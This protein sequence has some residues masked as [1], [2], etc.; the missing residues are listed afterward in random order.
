MSV[1]L[2]VSSV[3]TVTLTQPAAA[4]TGQLAAVVTA[5][6]VP[7]PRVSLPPLPPSM[8]QDLAPVPGDSRLTLPEPATVPPLPAATAGTK[9]QEPGSAFNPATS[10]VI[11]RKEFSRTWSNRDGTRT[12]ELSDQPI[13]VQ[14]GTGAWVAAD[15]AVSAGA[16]GAVVAPLHPLNPTF[17]PTAN[18]KK[19][20]TVRSGGEWVTFGL[21]G[22]AASPAQRG[23]EAVS[24]AGVLPGADLR[25][26]TT[27]ATVKE[28][29]VLRSAPGA[30]SSSWK[31][32]VTTSG[33]QPRAGR[34]GGIDFVDAAGTVVIAIPRA[35]MWDSSGVAGVSEPA[36]AD[37]ALSVTPSAGGWVLT[38]TAD[39]AWLAD[40]ARVYPVYVD[41]TA[42]PG[43]G[44][45]HIV[46]Y[47]SD[48]FACENCG[49]RIGNSRTNNTD[50][51]YRALVKYNYE[52]F[53]G[54]QILDAQLH[55]VV[56][57]GTANVAG[58]LLHH[59]TAFSY[60]GVGTML[61]PFSVGTEAWIDGPGLAGQLESWNRAGVSGAYLMLRAG[62]DAG[63][64]TYKNG[65][66]SLYVTWNQFPDPGYPSNGAPAD[67]GLQASVV[68][69]LSTNASDPDGDPL[70]FYYRVGTSPDVNASVVWQSGWTDS[71][72]VKI[73]DT[74]PLNAA[75][76]YYWRAFVRDP[77]LGA[78]G[79]GTDRWRDFS[80]T[81]HTPAPSPPQASAQPADR[82]VTTSTA[83]TFTTAAV[84]DPDG[85]PV[86]YR[87]TVAT[88][89]DGT[90][91][92]VLTSEWL[93]APSWTPPAGVLRDGGTYTWSVTVKD[94]VDSL[95]P[96]WRNRLTVNQRVGESGPAP[97]DSAGPV[98][99]NLANGNV[100]L[101][102]SSP[103][104]NTVGGPMGL[105]F[106][107][108]SLRPVARGLTGEY[109]DATTAVTGQTW[110]SFTGRSPVLTRTDPAIAY[111]WAL[112]SPGPAVPA[113]RFLIRWKGFVTPP[114]GTYTFGAGLDDGV[115]IR[116][117]GVLVFDNWIDKSIGGPY[118][119]SPVAFSGGPKSIQ[120]EYA[121]ISGGA[122]VGLMVRS[123]GQPDQV[124][125]PSWLSA[126]VPTLPAGWSAS[127]ALSGDGGEYSHAQVTESS[128]IITDTT[129]TAH[130]Y[131][132]TVPSASATGSPASGY[133]APEGEY[134]V[135]ALDSAGQVTLTEE[136]GAVHVFGANGRIASTTSPADALKP[137]APTTSYRPGTGQLNAITDPLSERKVR[138]AYSGDTM[139][140]IGL[141]GTGPA[142]AASGT[143][144][145]PPGGM[146]CRIFYPDHDPARA[147]DDTT[148]LEYDAYGRLVRIIDPGTEITSFGYDPNDRLFS[149]QDSVAN[150]W[151]TA[152]ATR[153]F[154]SPVATTIDYDSAGRAT[155]VT[156]P[157]ADGAKSSPRPGRIYTYA[158]ASVPGDPASTG[159][160]YVDVVGLSVPATAP[161]NG[162]ARTV[163]FDNAWRQLTDTSALGL[164]SRQ[165][166]N[167]RDMVLSATDPQG[168]MSTTVYDGLDRATDS[169][170]P[171]PAACFDANRLP[172]G[173]CPVT[174][175]HTRTG[176][177]EGLSGLSATYYAN[178]DLQGQPVTFGLGATG[179]TDGALAATWTTTPPGV[180]S[181]PFSARFTGRLTFPA[182][183]T[184]RLVTFG[185]DVVRLWVDDILRLD[186]SGNGT[187]TRSID[188][189]VQATAGQQSRIRVEYYGAD[190][191]GNLDL[192]WF[193]AAGVPGRVPGTQLTPD[194]GLVTSTTTDDSAPATAVGG[195]TAASARVPSETSRT[196]YDNP[197]LG[198]ATASVVDPTGLNLR[199]VTAYEAIGAGYLRRTEKRLPAAVSSGATAATAGITST[200]YG[201][202]ET[203]ATAYPSGVPC[204][205]PGTTVQAGMQR[206]ALSAVPSAGTRQV[207]EYVYD[208][209]GRA[210]GSRRVADAADP[211][212][213]WTCSTFDA[214][215]RTLTVTHPAYAGI[216]AR[217]VTSRYTANGLTP[218]T[219]AG[220]PLTSSVQDGN[221]PGSPNSGTIT[222]VSDLLGRTV[223][224]TD[225]WGT[226]SKVTYDLV[227]RATT[228]TTTPLGGVASVMTSTYDA[229][230]KPLTQSKDGAV[231]AT[232]TYGTG[233]TAGEL[234]GATYP[235]GTGSTGNG[236]SLAIGKNPAGAL[237]SLGWTFPA[238]Q[239]TG[240]STSVTDRVVRSQSGR[241]VDATTTDGTGTGAITRT[242]SYTYDRAGR[243]TG[244]ALPG[245]QLGYDYTSPADCTGV[246]GAVTNAGRN[247]NRMKTT[248]TIPAGATSATGQAMTA[249]TT[250]TGY[251]Y[252]AADRLLSTTTTAPPGGANP[253][254]AGNL[255]TAGGAAATLAYDTH[256]N[257]TRLADQT[258]VYD[259]ADRH[260]TTTTT[261]TTG[262]TP[263]RVTYVRDAADRIVARTETTNPGATGETSTT[264][265]YSYSAAGDTADLTLDATSQLVERI[266]SLPGGVTVTDRP[267][268]GAADVWA[269]PNIHG[270]V[271][272]TT[273]GAGIRTGRL[274][275]YDPFG[276][277][278]DPVSGLIGTRTADDAG[279]NTLTGNLDNGWL[280][281]HDR[282]Y[283]H[284]GSI[285]TTE[286]GAR[287]YVPA[288]G[289]FLEIDP[290]EGGVDNDYGYVTDP[291]NELDLDGQISWR[292]LAKG[293]IIVGAVAGAIACGLSVV[294]GLA[295][296]AAAGA[297]MYAAAHAGT[298]RFRWGG[299]AKGAAI[300]G[301]LGGV[302]RAR[303]AGEALR[304]LPAVGQSS[305]LFGN[306]S[307]GA[308]S[309]R[310][311]PP[312]RSGPRLGWSVRNVNGT[313]H[314]S[315]RAKV[316]GKYVDLLNGGRMRPR[317]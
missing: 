233:T 85:T 69:T 213:G 153:P 179:Q 76:R 307:M 187:N 253:V 47:K 48:G 98:S 169:Y 131:T 191:T 239:P 297:G 160:S 32:D 140:S 10:V 184:Y 102:F 28:M 123:T 21:Q 103:T 15:G 180:P 275:A 294:C 254:A 97:I 288:L 201:P 94:A 283:E 50:T 16:G 198:M 144:Q 261:A 71:R 219:P 105:T 2:V 66:T 59:A 23:V 37:V 271:L 296:G 203:L 147:V 295:V 11:E 190:S 183:G 200:Y 168:R 317:G 70:Q 35:G 96:A 143:G 56:Q 252:D 154:D 274:T 101:G 265:R 303:W 290:I 9:G 228:I 316:R 112:G 156:L 84:S 258:L 218:G 116:V 137:A 42:A 199:T 208:G 129:G 57:T 72:T 273:T 40:P 231:I 279:P 310:F 87:F 1:S 188:A 44:P 204:G 36:E 150:D 81:T 305:R 107:Y 74:A 65:N 264:Q 33:L 251:C 235:T 286:M 111:D 189:P 39:P 232:L 29:L 214:R 165:A 135:L 194:F 55:Y 292:T 89:Q 12:T 315:F 308:R 243:L 61:T 262:S 5:P 155:A 195:A 205:L 142:C 260:V 79:G 197:W 122:S 38:Q 170:G 114:A 181:G 299:L 226:V 266:H 300:G 284:A 132:K 222:T 285:A 120:V 178:R 51:Y 67:A 139:A 151:L 152:D 259:A 82:T 215:G 113:D 221:V 136:D 68:P 110:D 60:N 62:E 99:V 49:T 267:A 115:R 20:L 311:N 268:A 75:T 287:A 276:Q 6:V 246:T 301:A 185:D 217:T 250:A 104:V 247:G 133:S 280:G 210:V 293:A 209:L 241:V 161:S 172:L 95:R 17:A 130:T 124:L 64:Y 27:G 272:I 207:L 304:R 138:F 291:V 63:V 73:P 58:G 182:A 45:N 100:G 148:R 93:A 34:F 193:D 53:D 237:T 171:A 19:L 216:A 14:S 108:N 167:G 312:G 212:G 25:F 18:S 255:T 128:V 30:G 313:A 149:V 4:D 240:V 145:T 202:T 46:S 31:W 242:A 80:F 257:T 224:T 192:H 164:S 174:P 43:V 236:T 83:P 230:G 54:K 314:S 3:L 177:D 277:T 22:A 134:G 77:Y 119:G 256:G 118:Y 141:T 166:W 24:Y 278:V 158:T 281:Q 125:P 52:Q 146:I 306:A 263:T 159:S 109:F 269:Y 186:T 173:T 41:P 106:S 249:G 126:Q 298:N 86:Q 196:E 223:S 270:D 121:E 90:S 245:H 248:D 234:T 91:G 8:P 302:S 157:P 238:G 220:D 127:T 225:V 162:H 227:G 92:A 78:D 282:P 289:R 163:T 176:Y 244:A 229:D 206:Q 26:E 175:A 309:G 13:N 117:D 211:G 88:G 7:S